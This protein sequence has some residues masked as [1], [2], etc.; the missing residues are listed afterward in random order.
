MSAVAD[1]F[2]VEAGAIVASTAEIVGSP[3]SNV[4][5]PSSERLSSDDPVSFLVDTRYVLD[6]VSR[7]GVNSMNSKRAM[8][9]TLFGL[10]FGFVCWGLA[11]SESSI[12]WPLAVSIIISRTLMGFVIGISAL[13]WPWWLHGV[14]IGGLSSLPMGF[15]GLMAPMGGW[16]IFWGSIVMGVVYGFLTE[17]FTTVVFKAGRKA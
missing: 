2:C 10:I 16:S 1:Q 12:V 6:M 4:K 3:A 14:V 13:K 7:R 17:V 9:A 5:T 11:A 15:S 8:L